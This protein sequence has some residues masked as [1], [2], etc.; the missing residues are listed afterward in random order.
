MGAAHAFGKVK[1]AIASVA[2]KRPLKKR[3]QIV[4]DK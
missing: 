4:R 3:E 2:R 1:A